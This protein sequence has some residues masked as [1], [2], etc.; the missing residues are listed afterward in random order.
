MYEMNKINSRCIQIGLISTGLEILLQQ[1]FNLIA[2]LHSE[3][4]RA[5]MM[6]NSS[7]LLL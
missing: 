1:I 4:E 7:F 3:W 6:Y 2:A 5:I